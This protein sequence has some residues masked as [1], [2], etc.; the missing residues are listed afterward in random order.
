MRG[1]SVAVM[2]DKTPGRKKTSSKKTVKPPIPIDGGASPASPTPVMTGETGDNAPSNDR[3]PEIQGEIRQ[4]A[5]ELYEARGRQ[6]GF[7]EEDWIRAE[8]EILA[9]Y[10]GKSA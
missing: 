2:P 9:K 6:E 5:Y 7:Q 10:R 4:R 8:T 1:D 3:F